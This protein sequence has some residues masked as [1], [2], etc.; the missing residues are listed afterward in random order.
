MIKTGLEGT[1]HHLPDFIEIVRKIRILMLE[2]IL[3]HRSS[4]GL[5]PLH[6]LIHRIK[7]IDMTLG[8]LLLIFHDLTA[9]DTIIDLMYPI[10]KE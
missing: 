3:P 2:H 6:D 10:G 5:T 9:A 1:L 7:R 4:A 8:Q